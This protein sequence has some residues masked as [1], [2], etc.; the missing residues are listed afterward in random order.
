MSAFIITI[1]VLHV[2]SIGLSMGHISKNQYPRIV[3]NTKNDDWM[4][5][6]ISAAFAIWAG[7]LIF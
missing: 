1:F 3:T 6:I 2:V 4:T 7:V 5:L